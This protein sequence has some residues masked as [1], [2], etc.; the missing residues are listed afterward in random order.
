[1]QIGETIVER[2]EDALPTI[3]VEE[4]TVKMSFMVNISPFAG[5]EVCFHLYQILVLSSLLSSYV[6]FPCEYRAL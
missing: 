4:P 1:M 2:E 6:L 5:K 3:S